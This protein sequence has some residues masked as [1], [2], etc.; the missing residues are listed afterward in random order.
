MGALSRRSQPLRSSGGNGTW[1]DSLFGSQG[2]LPSAGSLPGAGAAFPPRYQTTPTGVRTPRSNQSESPALSPRAHASGFTTIPVQSSARTRAGV[3]AESGQEPGSTSIV[4]QMSAY[5]RRRSLPD[6]PVTWDQVGSGEA[7]EGDSGIWQIIWRDQAAQGSLQTLTF[8]TSTATRARMQSQVW[9]LVLVN[10]CEG[11]MVP[12]HCKLS[13][14][15]FGSVLI[16]TSPHVA[17]ESDS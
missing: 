13:F 1:W 6:A 2:D 3:A 14:L 11:R 9:K 4:S 8:E 7:T 16:I 15:T 12:G 17:Q 5:L 10:L